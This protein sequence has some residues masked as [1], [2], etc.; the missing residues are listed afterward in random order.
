MLAFKIEHNLEKDQILELYINQIYLGQ[1]AYGFAAASQIYFGKSLDKLNLPRRPMLAG[2]PKAPRPTTLLLIRN[3]PPAPAIRAA[4][5]ERT[6]TY[7]RAATAEATKAPLQVR[8]KSMILP[9]SRRIPG[10]NG[11]PGVYDQYPDEAYTKGFRVYTTIR[12]ADQ[13]AAYEA[14]RRGLLAYDRGQGYRGPKAFVELAATR[15]GRL[16]RSALRAS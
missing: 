4:A 14:V 16:R 12:K 8:G 15:R 7:H 5:H 6:W 1:R 2:L 11:A 9:G 13:R 10:R 3:A